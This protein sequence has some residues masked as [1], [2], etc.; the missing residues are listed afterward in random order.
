MFQDRFAEPELKK[1]LNIS[2]AGNG[3]TLSWPRYLTDWSLQVT[4]DLAAGTW[5]NISAVSR[6]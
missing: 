1:P 5:Q 3:L 2:R 4:N 6:S